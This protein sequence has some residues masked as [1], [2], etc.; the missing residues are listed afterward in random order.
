MNSGIDEN[1]TTQTSKNYEEFKTRSFV[2][3]TKMNLKLEEALPILE[4]KITK[5]IANLF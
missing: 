4:A 3:A 5:Q 1:T 2:E